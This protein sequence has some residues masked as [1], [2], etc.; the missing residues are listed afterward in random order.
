M[1]LPSVSSVVG[2]GLG[3]TITQEGDGLIC[4]K[5]E[6]GTI[7]NA[8]VQLKYAIHLLFLELLLCAIYF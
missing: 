6:V 8:E 4:C 7:L 1:S 2:L 5:A 3:R